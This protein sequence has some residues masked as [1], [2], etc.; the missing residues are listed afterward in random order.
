L[1]DIMTK[2]KGLQFEGC[3][4]RSKIFNDNGLLI[5]TLH[6]NDLI[7]AKKESARLKDLDD[8]D[9]LTKE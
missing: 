3:F 6:F 5:T 4:T 2:V 9:Q 7:R 1:I 8:I